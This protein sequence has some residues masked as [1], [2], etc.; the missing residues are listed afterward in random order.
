[1][2]ASSAP[3]ASPPARPGT[4]APVLAVFALATATGWAQE[5]APRF[6]ASESAEPGDRQEATPACAERWQW[7][8][9]LPQGDRFN[10]VTYAPGFGFVA[11]S[12]NG[13]VVTTPDGIALTVRDTGVDGVLKGIAYGNG[14]F[15]AVGRHNP[16]YLDAQRTKLVGGPLIITSP[17]TISW[18]VRSGPRE[19]YP[20]WGE[21][22]V[23]AS[24]GHGFVA[25][26]TDWDKVWTS[27]DGLTWPASGSPNG[28]VVRFRPE[29]LVWTG[30]SYA[31]AGVSLKD[32]SYH[33]YVATILENAGHGW[34]MP[35]FETGTYDLHDLAGGNGRI[36]AV[37]N[38]K[39]VT[40]YG[41][42]CSTIIS[43][44][45]NV[46]Y[47][48]VVWT[49]GI[50]RMLSAR[51]GG[52]VL[53][54]ADG[55]T[56]TKTNVPIPWPWKRMATDG[57]SILLVGY[58][59]E[60]AI[61]RDA[62]SWQ[63]SY[64][65]IASDLTAV[66][67]AGDRHIAV[68]KGDFFTSEDGASWRRLNQPWFQH[69]SVTSIVHGAGRLLALG[70][71]GTVMSSLDGTSWQT[72][73][74][75]WEYLSS[76]LWDGSRFLVL[77]G[78]RIFAS[79]DG[80]DWVRIDDGSL[81]VAGVLAWTGSAYFAWGFDLLTSPDAVHWSVAV[82]DQSHQYLFGTG[83][84]WNGHTLVLVGESLC[85]V[86]P[87]CSCGS[88]VMVT[89]DGA[90]WRRVSGL[91][92]LEEITWDGRRFVAAG[93]DCVVSSPDGLTWTY[94][95]RMTG[96]RLWSIASSGRSTVVVGGTTIR[97]RV[98]CPEPR[99]IRKRIPRVSR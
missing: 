56:W 19:D 1:M 81:S 45:Y 98:N 78:A 28:V 25:M 27:P 13:A 66:T 67:W 54:S 68:G 16:R 82:K 30:W 43:L 15:V 59:G 60:V 36:V 29:R 84:A 52:E 5:L 58:K 18:T 69:P 75:P 7:A 4:C 65:T 99:M 22:K 37:G 26:E 72:F 17:D 3:V 88:S 90:S 32:F 20:G 97:Y 6:R 96:E 93:C 85:D 14:L 24:D 39:A 71:Y 76:A 31:A 47:G 42:A 44:P 80:Q 89:T 49:D 10:D 34:T 21:L 38:N 64:S 11:V 9:P 46:G 8:S 50:F 87:P 41:G 92:Y 63:S 35:F 79:T 86:S 55:M 70:N 62:R 40:C 73:S 95:A 83:A 61:S 12:E 2:A 53:E 51:S 77:D 91:P 33:N 74:G 57:H 23:V 48:S 94:E